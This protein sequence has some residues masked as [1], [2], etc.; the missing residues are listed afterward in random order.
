MVKSHSSLF[1]QSA[2]FLGITFVSVGPGDP[3]LL[4][5]AAIDAIENST[6]IAFPVAEIGSESIALKIASSWVSEKQKK[7]PIDMPMV[8]NNKLLRHAWD[9]AILK[10]FNAFKNGDKVVYLCEGDISLFASGSYLIHCLR[11]SY[12]DCPVRTIPGVTSAST[13]SAFGLLPLALQKE[14]VLILPTPDDPISFEDYLDQ[15]SSHQRTLVF[16]KLGKRWSWVRPILEKKGLL[17]N[18][19]FA[20]QLCFSEERVSLAKDV[21]I[22]EMPY[23]SLLIVRQSWPSALLE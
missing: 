3:S 23:F 4:T 2:P 16:L 9:K 19:L 11:K 17:S 14:Q 7:M 8:S 18:A 15:A 10:L 1:S 21:P 5:L 20:K 12:P 13:A 6:C 22:S